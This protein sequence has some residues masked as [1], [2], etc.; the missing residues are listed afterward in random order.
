MAKSNTLSFTV[1]DE[2]KLK[3]DAITKIGYYDSLSE[4]L[5]DAIRNILTKNKDLRLA[6][7]FEL[8]KNKRIT[9]G[10]AAEITHLSLNE[11]KQHFK[12]REI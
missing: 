12:E 6:I 1:P 9:L 7:G 4:F 11:I 5:R 2:L 8:Y 10:K 3:L